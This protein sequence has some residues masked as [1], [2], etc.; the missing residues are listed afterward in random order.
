MK[1]HSVKRLAAAA[2][3][4]LSTLAPASAADSCYDLWYARNLIFAENGFCF[5]SQL[6]MDT[7][8]QFECWTDAPKL[9]RAEQ[10]EVARIKAIE[11]R[12]GC[13]VN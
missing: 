5:K 11:K 13:K 1:R 2:C 6:G 7:F 9:T 10:R 8:A 3:L 4:T 12:R